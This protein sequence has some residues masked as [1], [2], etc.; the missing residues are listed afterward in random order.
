MV[1][2]IEVLVNNQID[3]IFEFTSYDQVDLT[4]VNLRQILDYCKGTSEEQ[5][6]IRLRLSQYLKN[7]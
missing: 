1:R 6:L 2:Y 4:L 7:E 5:Q 3:T